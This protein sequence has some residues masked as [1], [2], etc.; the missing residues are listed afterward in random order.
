MRFV[1]ALEIGFPQDLVDKVGDCL[2]KLG[3]RTGF[4]HVTF[5]LDPTAPANRSESR[6]S[7]KV[8][9]ACRKQ[10][11][12][13]GQRQVYFPRS[14]VAA[15]DVIDDAGVKYLRAQGVSTRTMMDI[16]DVSA[17]ILY[18]YLQAAPPAAHRLA[19][20]RHVEHHQAEF[21]VGLAYLRGA[22]GTTNTGA[23]ADAEIAGLIEKYSAGRICRMGQALDLFRR[24]LKRDP[25]RA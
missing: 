10:V 7:L 20:V 2:T 4:R 11:A 13:L 25:I 17:P 6:L 22:E 15:T 3:D 14:S 24:G 5:Q 23:A 9:A 8:L 19:Q 18:R 1:N 12:L 21:D 16:Y